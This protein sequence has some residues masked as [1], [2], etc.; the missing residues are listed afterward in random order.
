MQ[1]FA[2]QPHVAS[3]YAATANDTTRHAPLAGTID[4]D[5][6]VIG[7]GLLACPPR[8]IS[9]SAAI[10]SPC[11]KRRESDGRRAATAAS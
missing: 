2:N 5:V 6:C 1:T 9:P 11:S 3:Y 7:A 8:S 10:R 4:A